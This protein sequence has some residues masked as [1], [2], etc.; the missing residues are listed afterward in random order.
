MDSDPDLQRADQKAAYLNQIV[1]Y[2]EQVLRSIN[3]RTFL[4]K[5]AI[6]WKKFTSG[7]I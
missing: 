1:K 5:N 4:I 6:E 3:N 7:A 2:L